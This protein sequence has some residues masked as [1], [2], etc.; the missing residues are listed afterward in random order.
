[1]ARKPTVDEWKAL[2]LALHE[3]AGGCCEHID[4]D[5][6]RCGRRIPLDSMCFDN[7]HHVKKRSAGGKM[8]LSDTALFCGPSNYWGRKDDSCHTK[9]HC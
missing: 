7:V 4:E 1:M 9:E 2:G 5:G 8:T 3:R 6:T